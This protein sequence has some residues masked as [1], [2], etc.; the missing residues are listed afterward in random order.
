[1]PTSWTE[2]YKENPCLPYDYEN[3]DDAFEAI[4]SDRRVATDFHPRYQTKNGR[5]HP[6]EAWTFLLPPPSLSL[7]RNAIGS[8]H[9]TIEC[10]VGSF[11]KRRERDDD[12]RRR[13]D[14]GAF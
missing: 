9:I 6:S 7:V 13:D 3:I 11:A 10:R 4:S 2:H 1:M 8:A 12:C 14:D 5:S